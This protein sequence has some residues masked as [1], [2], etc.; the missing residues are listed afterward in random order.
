MNAE[1]SRFLKSLFEASELN[2][3]PPEYGGHRLFKE[4]T[5]GVSAGNDPIFARF[6]KV[7]TRNHL[8]PAEMWS[9]SA[10]AKWVGKN[11]NPI[12]RP[13]PD[14]GT[15]TDLD[16]LAAKLKVLS[17]VFPYTRGIL[18]DG[19]RSSERTPLT[20]LALN[21]AHVFHTEVYEK[22]VQFFVENGC[23]IMAPQK[24][25]WHSIQ[26][27]FLKPHIV[28]V[29]SERHYAF[30]AGL[31]TFG[32]ADHLI[33]EH[34]CNVRLASFITDAPLEITPRQSDDPY[35]NCLHF[36]KGGCAKCAA[37]CPSRALTKDGH[38]KVLCEFTR[39]R[40]AAGIRDELQPFLKPV[41]RRIEYFAVQDYA[42]GCGICQYDVPCMDRNPMA[43]SEETVPQHQSLGTARERH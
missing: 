11:D 6:K 16:E 19:S 8:T 10:S 18:E 35:A 25:R 30:A 4:P 43:D 41:E 42:I 5:I 20:G 14:G 1:V 17:I 36:A 31:G 40:V 28:S 3:L 21:R 9:K 32:L 39:R 34:G 37:R 13:R 2:C 22:T 24:S 23:R 27:T 26:F 15:W 12:G 29:W 7:V 38:G 33:T